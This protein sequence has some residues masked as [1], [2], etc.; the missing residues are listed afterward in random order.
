MR[1]ILL[2]LILLSDAFS[3]AALAH[4]VA[5]A[6]TANPLETV[7]AA[8]GVACVWL[9]ARNAVWN[10]PVGIVSCGL[11]LLV[12]RQARLYSDAGLQVAFIVLNLYGWRQW[13]RRGAAAALPITG[14]SARL[15]AG[16]LAA[17][18]LYA[19]GAGYL[20]ARYT[21]A[22]LPYY[23]SATT[24]V[25]LVAQY[26]LSRRKIENWL[27]WIAVDVVYV[28][29]YW[30]R[31]LVLTSGLYVFFLGLAAYGYWQWRREQAAA[32]PTTS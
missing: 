20:F 16:L 29:L 22:A 24:A 8:T 27:L 6:L 11:Y 4:S 17:A 23:D 2:V 25:S 12:F 1:A 5:A 32:F 13:Q 28:R 15:W 18:T 30:H 26:L 7:A 3:P 14:T 19:V 21:N 10:F 31:D 9:A